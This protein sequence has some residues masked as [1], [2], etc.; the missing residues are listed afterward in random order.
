[1]ASFEKQL[2]YRYTLA[3]AK[4]VPASGVEA[5]PQL[6]VTASFYRGRVDPA[7]RSLVKIMID[8]GLFD[9]FIAGVFQGLA[10]TGMSFFTS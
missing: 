7:Y 2:L 9:D 1:M 4:E 10:S 5:G 3:I 8:D 6:D